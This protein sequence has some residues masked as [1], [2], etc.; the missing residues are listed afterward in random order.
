M[1][2]IMGTK[3]KKKAAEKK[4][5]EEQLVQ[6]RIEVAKPGSKKYTH[7]DW[8]ELLKSNGREKDEEVLRRFY[9]EDTLFMAKKL[10][11]TKSKSGKQLRV[12][13]D[14][15][16]YL[17][18]NCGYDMDDEFIDDTEAVDDMNMTAKKGRFYVG[19]GEVKA[20]D[21][22]DEEEEESE[23]EELEVEVQ[24]RKPRGPY[25][26]K[27][28]EGSSD[29]EPEPPVRM[30]GQAPTAR[31]TGA[32][33][34]KKMKRPSP[35]AAKIEPTP[36]PE[37]KK[38]VETEEKRPE[39]SRIPSVVSVASTSSTAASSVIIESPTKPAPVA[40]SSFSSSTPST[41]SSLLA[42]STTK[43]SAA[44][45]MA[46]KI[47][48]ILKKPTPPTTPSKDSNVASIITSKYSQLAEK[49]K[50]FKAAGMKSVDATTK[51]EFKDLI[52]IAKHHN[53]EK[54][55]IENLVTT[56]SMAFGLSTQELVKLVE[57]NETVSVKKEPEVSEWRLT[58]ADVPFMT[59]ADIANMTTLVK[60]WRS[61]K[62]LPN[63][64]LTAWLKD[65]NQGRLNVDRAR[66]RLFDYVNALPD[67]EKPI[68]VDAGFDLPKHERSRKARM[69][70][71]QWVWLS[72]KYIE[73][74]LPT[75]KRPPTDG[76]AKKQ[77]MAVN[78][79]KEAYRKQ[80]SHFESKV[81]DRTGADAIYTFQFTEPVLASIWTYLDELVDY[82][83]SSGKLDIIVKGIDSLHQAVDDK[84]TQI[85][86][87]IELCRRFQKLSFLAVEEPMKGRLAT[88]KEL[89]TKH[90]VVQ[91]V[92]YMIK[93]PGGQE[94]SMRGLS[95]EFYSFETSVL[96]N[97][98]PLSSPRASNLS[99]PSMV[100]SSSTVPAV[101]V[102]STSTIVKPS[103]PAPAPLA[104]RQP[105]DEER[106]AMNPIVQV[107]SSRP[108]E[109]SDYVRLQQHLQRQLQQK[110]YLGKY[111]MANGNSTADICEPSAQPMSDELLVAAITAVYVCGVPLS[112]Q[113]I[114]L[115]NVLTHA[116]QIRMAQAIAAHR[117]RTSAVLTT[118]E[119]KGLFEY[120]TKFE[121]TIEAKRLKN[122]EFEEK[123]RQRTEEKQRKER[124]KQAEKEKKE[125]EKQAERERK[126]QEKAEERERK[127]RE[128]REERERKERE[129]EE[130]RER[131]RKEEEDRR[132]AQ[133][134]IQRRI[135]EERRRKE[136]EETEREETERRTRMETEATNALLGLEEDNL[137]DDVDFISEQKSR[138]DEERKI[139]EGRRAVERENQIKMMRAQQL[140]RQGPSEGTVEE[141]SQLMGAEVNQP[142]FGGVQPQETA[143]QWTNSQP[144]P[145][146]QQQQLTADVK[147]EHNSQFDIL[148]AAQE[149]AGLPA[150][151][152]PPKPRG[153]FE[154]LAQLRGRTLSADAKRRSEMEAMQREC[155]DQPGTGMG[156]D[157]G[158][159]VM[160]NQPVDPQHYPHAQIDPS[161]FGTPNALQTQQQQQ[162][163]PMPSTNGM[164]NQD[165]QLMS[166]IQDHLQS[167]NS[168]HYKKVTEM[169]NRFGYH[170]PQLPVDLQRQEHM[171]P[172]PTPSAQHLHAL[173]QHQERQQWRPQ[174][175][176]MTHMNGAF[177]A[178]GQRLSSQQI[179]QQQSEFVARQQAHQQRMQQQQQQRQ[180]EHREKM[181]QMHKEQQE[182]QQQQQMYADSQDPGRRS[183][184]ISQG[185][186]PS[187]PR[188]PQQVAPN[189]Q[190]PMSAYQSP[191][192]NS[193]LMHTPMSNSSMVA[194]SPQFPSHPSPMSQQFHTP[195]SVGMLNPTMSP[196]GPAPPPP[197]QHFNFPPTYSQQQ[198]QVPMHRQMSQ[199]QMQQNA[200]MHRQM[201]QQ[202][203][204]YPPP[205]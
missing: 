167:P 114:M 179:V 151:S 26:K 93:W 18:R 96:A 188:T 136:E 147:K 94:P 191:M 39:P 68:A 200:M 193:S 148:N 28:K 162:F 192:T 54:A 44:A 140:M 65:V 205:H 50:M 198:P 59:D 186:M 61:K 127:E 66:Q 51:Q 92:K 129:K 10:S 41:S 42:S 182:Q 53:L 170:P 95:K 99:R 119:Y 19:K 141:N 79:L 90:Q 124:E 203:H 56:I 144:E 43:A 23:E 97:W 73:T 122:K 55:N 152:D 115:K 150:F 126:E 20:M 123:E 117:A 34:T 160:N 69:F 105:T 146:Q 164:T 113:M 24:Q 48:N 199:Q 184:S 104:A 197:L 49:G 87:Y 8:Q 190:F 12:N 153:A 86:F 75:L 176:P 35:P 64:V 76:Y 101:S 89:I 183:M 108:L 6:I 159:M 70:L 15:I 172:A 4:K 30:T 102:P 195:P 156:L 158:P 88:A 58:A 106:R 111:L 173:M 134:E 62:Q 187:Q 133:I 22:V 171:N 168:E 169:G 1:D 29:S 120:F 189:Q 204:N 47:D 11:E 13:L 196:M 7:V 9:D 103:A 45:V 201:S 77:V 194:Q 145:Q 33:P 121:K 81:K 100:P 78:S 60:S 5:N 40:P 2:S 80:L 71:H 142:D 163:F 143:V 82:S 125:A 107:P 72:R 116:G 37:K 17:N 16:Q 3:K 112:N 27:E 165:S 91:N 154:K 36:P 157:Q 63:V 130:E 31:M 155:Q 177:P 149:A 137:M 52:R 128:K 118:K 138:E 131:K 74:V 166:Q 180:K 57:V 132:T 46:K 25:K 174:Q 21:D 139:A 14:H 202:H 83:L 175:P 161:P 181:M 178:G 85:Q 84:V 67:L 110:V 38:K 135:D 32:P 185:M 98:K 109:M